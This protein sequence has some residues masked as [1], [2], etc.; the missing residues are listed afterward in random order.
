MIISGV[1]SYMWKLIN[2]SCHIFYVIKTFLFYKIFFHRIG[3]SSA[4]WPPVL[5]SFPSGIS[6]GH[7]VIVRSGARMEL[8]NKRFGSEFAP[9]LEIG[10]CSTIEQN[11]HIACAE[12]ISIGNRV[13]VA[14]H[15]G[16]FDILHPY[17]DID[18]AISMQLL[19]TAAVSIGDDC[20]IGMGAVIHPG[21]S[22]G[23][24]CMI[25]ANSVVTK[26]IPDYSV[27]VGS[28]AKIIRRY[29]FGTKQWRST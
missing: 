27:A 14:Q 4:I 16:I 18:V 9:R 5:I 13:T 28:P 19:K 26:N 25:G 23:R 8:I 10:D 22:I 17:E 1:S 3:R 20:F 15:V 24:H 6:I 12:K 7:N 2:Y 29:D 21:V 11:V